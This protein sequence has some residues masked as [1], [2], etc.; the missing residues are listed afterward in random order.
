M[1]NKNGE[2]CLFLWLKFLAETFNK[3]KHLITL[4]FNVQ[5]YLFVSFRYLV[6]MSSGHFSVETGRANNVWVHSVLN[7]LGP[8]DQE[9]ISIYQNGQHVGNHTTINQ[10]STNAPDGKIVIGRVFTE[11]NNFYA[12]VQVDEL[13][14]FNQTLTEAEIR[15]LS[16]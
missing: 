15:L 7:F 14:F 4:N 11:I 8:N 10:S 5:L 13:L 16:Q 12:S 2:K 3:H 6:S 1:R 9:G